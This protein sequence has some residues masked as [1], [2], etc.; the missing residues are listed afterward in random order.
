MVDV[1]KIKTRKLKKSLSSK[2]VEEDNLQNIN[3]HTNNLKKNDAVGAKERKKIKSRKIRMSFSVKEEKQ[4]DKQ[5]E[6]FEKVSIT[7]MVFIL[8][9][10]FIVGVSLGYVLY[11]IAINSSS[12]MFIVKDLLC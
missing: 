10:C 12:A 8:V 6:T 4:M 9:L 11:R 5:M 2:K 1:K 3:N 7:V